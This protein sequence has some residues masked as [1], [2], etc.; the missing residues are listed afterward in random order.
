MTPSLLNC[1]EYMII[2]EVLSLERS[3]ESPV[4][5]PFASASWYSLS[6]WWIIRHLFSS[7]LGCPSPSGFFFLEKLPRLPI[8]HAMRNELRFRLKELHRLVQ[9][10][11]L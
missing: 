3:F 5:V 4:T 1:T 2:V 11:R 10:S 6:G 8:S 7:W 9:C